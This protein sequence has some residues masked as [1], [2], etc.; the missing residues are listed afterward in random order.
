MRVGIIDL[1]TNSVRFDVHSISEKGK[2]KLLHR[3]K[4]MIRL[5][6]GVF[7]KGRMN[8]NAIH[9]TLIA[10]DHFRRVA[11]NLRC[12]KIVAFG[13]SALRE[14]QDSNDL[15]EKLLARSGIELRVISGKE[16]AKLIALGVL[17]NEVLPTG[18]FALVDIGGG[19]TEISLCR[20]RNVRFGESFQLGTA[21][22]Q[23]VFLRRSP[24]KPVAVQQLRAYIRNILQEK[25]VAESWPKV[26]QI[27]ASSGTAKAIAKLLDKKSKEGFTLAELTELVDEL[28]RKTTTELLDMPGMEPKRVDMILAGALLLE[29]TAIALGARKILLSEFSLRDGIIEEERRLAQ[30]QKTSLIEL[31]LDDLIA[32][33]VS[34]GGH[35]AHM[36][37]LAKLAEELFGR[38]QNIHRLDKRWK[39][40][41]LAAVIFRN[42][43][44]LVGFVG[45]EKHA[46]YIVK[47]LDIQAMQ[48]WEHGFIADLCL[49]QS[50]GKLSPKDINGIAKERRAAFRKLL[51]LLRLIVAVD[52]GHNTTLNLR[53]VRV[54][55]EYVKL[56]FSGKAAAGLEQ[57]LIDRKKKLF[58]DEFGRQL[59]LEGSRKR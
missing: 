22:L 3:E 24:P 57:L 55:R 38:L 34:F 30:F 8:P 39:V 18:A 53:S 58:E 33:A 23:Q 42:C 25:L 50:G 59:L 2:T 54:T 47:N 14:A 19:S 4:L 27:V 17:E 26:S 35:E 1:G 36:R 40:Y 10:F 32:R 31:H 49:H 51:G 45:K 15:V 11:G 43:G 21:R 13:T 46:H 9:R 5:G 37:H 20:G 12:R 16:E 7:L 48:A 56:I 44:E 28:S 29:E 6:Q 52:L 41:L